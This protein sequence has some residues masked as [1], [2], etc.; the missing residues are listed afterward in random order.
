M[1]IW[2]LNDETNM[3]ASDE[4]EEI[5]FMAREQEPT[6]YALCETCKPKPHSLTRCC[7]TN[8]Q[9]DYTMINTTKTMN[10]TITTQGLW[11]GDTGASCHMTNSLNGMTKLKQT[12][13]TIQIGDGKS[14]TGL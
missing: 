7:G 10:D 12:N 3:M 2:Y 14:I 8:E 13:T 9:D 4:M 6:N 5:V 11:I 1:V